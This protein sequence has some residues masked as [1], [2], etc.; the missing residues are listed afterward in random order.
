MNYE[1]D[2]VGRIKITIAVDLKLRKEEKYQLVLSR[3]GWDE[4]TRKDA[5][6]KFNN[7]EKIKEVRN[8]IEAEA[9]K[10][11]KKLDSIAFN[12]NSVEIIVFVESMHIN[13]EDLNLYVFIILS[14]LQIEKKLPKGIVVN[15]NNIIVEYI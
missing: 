4:K 8:F 10:R 6:K 12:E 1:K 15:E 7:F 11:G 9:K 14:F 3:V 5:L 2:E 13:L